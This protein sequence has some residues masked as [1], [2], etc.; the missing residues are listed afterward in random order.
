MMTLMIIM[1]LPTT[2]NPRDSK[3]AITF[4]TP[5]GRRRTPPPQMT[6]ESFLLVQ[7]HYTTGRIETRTIFFPT[8]IPF[9]FTQDDSNIIIKKQSLKEVISTGVI[10]KKNDVGS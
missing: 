4:L 3:L 7:T 1:S 9:W 8:K 10:F 2:A 5:G 6:K